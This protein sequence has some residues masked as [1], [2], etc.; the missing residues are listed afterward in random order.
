[1]LTDRGHL[2]H[3]AHLSLQHG[4]LGV[5]TAQA[6]AGAPERLPAL[7][8]VVLYNN[9][10]VGAAGVAALAASPLLA[11]LPHLDANG[12]EMGRAGVAALANSPHAA[13]LVSLNVGGNKFGPEG[14]QALLESPQLAR[15][16]SLGLRALGF[17]AKDHSQLLRWPAGRALQRLDL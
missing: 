5:A 13:Y 17:K 1:A 16:R 3:V 4:Y 2:A 7:R 9:K 12:V 14:L 10:P 11:R 8:S 6:L 15:L